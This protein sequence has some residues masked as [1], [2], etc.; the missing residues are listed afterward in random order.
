[1]RLR[2]VIIGLVVL[3]VL[4]TAGWMLKKSS[5]PAFPVEIRCNK[6]I[7]RP[8]IAPSDN[9]VLIL[10]PDGTVWG[11][12]KNSG[13]LLG[14]IN[15]R[16]RWN[17]PRRLEVGSDW[18]SLAAGMTFAVGTKADGSLWGWTFNPYRGPKSIGTYTNPPTQLAPGTNWRSVAAGAGHGLALR[19]DGTLW[20]W[21]QNDHGQ[22]GDGTTN[23]PAT[24][25]PIGTNRNWT[26]MAAGT[27]VSLG[28]QA[29]GSLWQWG[30]VH[31]G[32][33][34]GPNVNLNQPTRVGTG[35]DWT[36][37]FANDHCH[38]ARQRD[39]SLWV[40]GPNAE[41]FFGSTNRQ[42]PFRLAGEKSWVSVAGRGAPFHGLNVDGTIW[43]GRYEAGNP[44]Q[45]TQ[46]GSRADWVS[47]CGAG[48]V[49]GLTQDGT[50]WTWGFILEERS[51]FGEMTRAVNDW[52]RE[53]VL[54]KSPLPALRDTAVP[55][56]L[57]HFSTNTVPGN[58]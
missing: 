52:F 50:L 11:W 21:G 12:G 57:V 10:A 58:R 49:F 34:Q 45:G 31:A 7:T 39:G 37:I 36:A 51:G 38:L 35:T 15:V 5:Q 18:V 30:F 8:Q 33:N 16:G 24:P 29:D 9:A 4:V 26:A 28:L 2:R 55:W 19:A 41:A 32:Y 46:V 20:G 44:W 53:R 47:L 25:V 3:A 54:R 48:A 6:I 17:V 22:V 42:F 56:A 14:P 1:M 23:W 40:W 13:G 27:F 43:C